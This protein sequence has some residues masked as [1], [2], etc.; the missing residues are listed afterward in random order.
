MI[1]VSGQVFDGAGEPVADALLEIWQADPAGGYGGGEGFVGFGRCPTDA[2]GRYR[3]RTLFPGRAP[4]PGGQAPAE[5]RTCSRPGSLVP[6][7][8]GGGGA[9]VVARARQG[10]GLDVGE[11]TRDGLGRPVTVVAARDAKGLEFDAVV[12]VEPS[13]IAEGGRGLRVLY[14]ALTRPTQHLSI[15]TTTGL[16]AALAG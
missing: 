13:R 4:A 15:V 3:F 12:V 7:G 16:P 6:G 11:A 1:E 5:H 14:V 9:G 8:G 2:E 10:G